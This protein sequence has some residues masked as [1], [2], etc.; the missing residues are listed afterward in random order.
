MS[1][2]TNPLEKIC[3]WIWKKEH[4]VELRLRDGVTAVISSSDDVK[5]GDSGLLFQGQW[6]RWKD[7][8]AI[9][10]VTSGEPVMSTLEY[11]VKAGT[12]QKFAVKEDN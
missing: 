2:D 12:L 7:V 9:Y 6:L 1:D 5:F 3:Q 11:A 4:E 8:L 10:D